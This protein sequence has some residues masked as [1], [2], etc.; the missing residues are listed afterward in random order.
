MKP[1]WTPNRLGAYECKLGTLYKAIVL[2]NSRFPDQIRCYWRI[3][4]SSFLPFT[5]DQYNKAFSDPEEC[6][7][8]AEGIVL[9]W[10]SSLTGTKPD[11]LITHS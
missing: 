11:L 1:C 2:V 4:V 10:L 7:A 6:A 8:F 3:S 9:E 5:D